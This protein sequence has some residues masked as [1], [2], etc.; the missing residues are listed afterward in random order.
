MSKTK[1]AITLEAAMVRKVD[2]LVK[3]HVFPNRSRAIQDA[4][5]EKLVRIEHRRLAAEC[6]KLDR[7]AERALAEEG[8]AMET[9]QWPE[10]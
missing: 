7:G 2:G 6:A 1:I 9:E 3:R 5:G 10:Y 8:I 4:L